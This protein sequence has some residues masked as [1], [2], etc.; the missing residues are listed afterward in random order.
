MTKMECSNIVGK[1][2]SLMTRCMG[3]LS[4]LSEGE[5]RA[6]IKEA[7]KEI[8]HK[9]DRQRKEAVT[10]AIMAIRKVYEFSHYIEIETENGM[11]DIYL[12]DIEAALEELR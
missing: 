7:T 10:N 6:L 8:A 11:Q 3:S 5:L 9:K 1:E 2:I 12:T 4:Q